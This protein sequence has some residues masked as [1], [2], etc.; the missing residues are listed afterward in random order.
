MGS[1]KLLIHYYYNHIL[2]KMKTAIIILYIIAAVRSCDLKLGLRQGSSRDFEDSPTSD[3][4]TGENTW[5]NYGCAVNNGKCFTVDYEMNKDN[6]IRITGPAN[7]KGQFVKCF[8]QLVEKCD[9]GDI[10]CSGRDCT[11]TKDK[12]KRTA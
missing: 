10:G 3:I 8:C 1:F 4:E 9:N 5:K 12:V 7:T 2:R 11:L 6:E